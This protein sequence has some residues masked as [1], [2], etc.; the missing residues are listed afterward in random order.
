MVLIFAMIGLAIVSA[1]LFM[2][3]QGTRTSGAFKIYKSADEAGLGGT[4][5]TV[6]LIKTVRGLSAPPPNLPFGLPGSGAGLDLCLLEKLNGCSGNPCVPGWADCTAAR[7]SMDPTVSWDYFIDLPGPFGTS[8]RAYS[9]IVSSV[10]GNT[11]TSGLVTTG[12]LGGAG[13]VASAS[14]MV[15]PP[16]VPY[17][18]SVEVQTQNAANPMEKARYSTLYAY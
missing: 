17:L 9:K 12:Q 2:L 7:L 1:M 6:E 15:S 16:A 13:V 10:Q 3:T 8:F 18:Y 5:A 4:I 14:G 11:D